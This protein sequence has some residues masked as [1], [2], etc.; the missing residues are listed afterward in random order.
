MPDPIIL[1]KGSNMMDNGD[2]I[3][4]Y[5][6]FYWFELWN[7]LKSTIV[8]WSLGE[9]WTAYKGEAGNTSTQIVTS[10]WPPQQYHEYYLGTSALLNSTQISL[11][12]SNSF[13][14]Q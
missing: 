11:L 5:C 8:G 12:N 9:P 6:R 4:F 1:G 10:V 3:R 13:A 7:I 14:Q 2:F